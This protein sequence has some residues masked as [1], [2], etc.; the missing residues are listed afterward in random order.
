MIAIMSEATSKEKMEKDLKYSFEYY[1]AIQYERDGYLLQAA[2]IYLKLVQEN[3]DDMKAK[4]SLIR[5]YRVIKAK[6]D[7][8][9]EILRDNGKD[10]Y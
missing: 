6:N 4:R 2:D 1:E 8:L 5:V 3:P 9:R 7:Q 10:A